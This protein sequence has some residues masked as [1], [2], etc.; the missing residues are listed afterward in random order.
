[1]CVSSSGQPVHIYAKHELPLFR[2]SR[3][4]RACVVS[5]GGLSCFIT[6]N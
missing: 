3:A 5:V 6:H 4:R 2:R 1:M